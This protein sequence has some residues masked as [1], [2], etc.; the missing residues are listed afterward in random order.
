MIN[1]LKIK[2]VNDR[3]ISLAIVFQVEVVRVVRPYDPQGGKSLK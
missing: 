1:S 3:V 2:N